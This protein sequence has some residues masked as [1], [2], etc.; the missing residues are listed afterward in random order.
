LD[1]LKYG[2]FQ[3]LREVKTVCGD[4]WIVAGDFNMIY[5]S[6]DKNNSNINR[7]LLQD[8]RSLINDLDLKV[9][10]LHGRKFTWSNQRDSPTLVK[11]D[12]VF[13]TS[14]WED[15]FPDHAQVSTASVTSDHCPIILKLHEEF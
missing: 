13:C 5:S 8:F 10:P 6:D 3:E 7:S 1:S 2:F 4:P 9:V 12:H 14:T 15:L 11:L